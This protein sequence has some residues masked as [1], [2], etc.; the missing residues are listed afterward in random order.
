MPSLPVL[1]AR[2]LAGDILLHP[3]YGYMY[4]ASCFTELALPPD[5]P[6]ADSSCPALS[7]VSMFRREGPNAMHEVLPGSMPFRRDRRG[8]QAGVDALRHGRV[9]RAPPN[10][11]RPFRNC[12]ATQSRPIIPRN[13]RRCCWGAQQGAVVPDDRRQWWAVCAVFRM[14]AGLP[15]CDQRAACGPAESRRRA[16]RCSVSKGA[17]WRRQRDVSGSAS[18]RR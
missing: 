4:Y 2:S 18:R 13:V 1:G 10:N 16:T 11:S 3:E 8:G 15:D 9:R 14:Y 17:E 5:K 6:L 7:C 12:C